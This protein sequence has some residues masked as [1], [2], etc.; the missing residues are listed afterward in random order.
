MGNYGEAH[1]C[2]DEQLKLCQSLPSH[3]PQ[4]GKCYEN[5]AN[6]YDIEGEKP[7]ALIHYE[8]AYEIYTQSLPAY[9][10]D[11][12]KVEQAIESLSL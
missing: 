10:P 8:K 12:T 1:K 9:H 5:I 3:H 6:L 7:L 2:F 11:T 4:C